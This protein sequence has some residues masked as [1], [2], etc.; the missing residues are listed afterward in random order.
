MADYKE[1]PD[2]VLEPGK[3]IRSVDGYAFRDNLLA[4][5][6]GASNAPRIQTPALAEQSVTT[7][8][9]ADRNI[10]PIK[11]S[12]DVLP[13][14]INNVALQGAGAIGTYGFMRGPY[15]IEAGELVAGSQLFWAAVA[16][17]S[18]HSATGTWRCMGETGTGYVTDPESSG[19]AQAITLWQRVA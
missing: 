17:V 12:D 13:W 8:K 6:F 14:I 3:P 18:H 1:I 9:V 2:E 16:V 11:L 10:T 19:E 4:V 5:I 15:R 7:A